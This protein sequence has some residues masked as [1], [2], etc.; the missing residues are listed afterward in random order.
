MVILFF[1][2]LPACAYSQVSI[3]VAKD[4]E[5]V[6][7]TS[8]ESGVAVT[9]YAFNFS[10][11]FNFYEQ[12]QY[13]KAEKYFRRAYSKI[14][15]REAANYIYSCMLQ[16][17]YE[18]E[19]DVFRKKQPDLINEWP[20]DKKGFGN[21]Y[22]DFGPRISANAN[23]GNID[24]ANGGFLYKVS[25][26]VQYWQTAT[27]L[28]QDNNLGNY[29]QYGLHSS[30]SMQLNNGWNIQPS[31]N[32]Y[33]TSYNSIYTQTA[34][35]ESFSNFIDPKETI[36][37]QT[38]G[39]Q[40]TNYAFPGHSHYLNLSV[41]FSK[42]IQLF[43]F[44]LEPAFHYSVDKST[45]LYQYFSNG[46]TDSFVN[47]IYKGSAPFTASGVGSSDTTIRSYIGQLGISLLYNWPAF[48]QMISTRIAFYYL[49]GEH[50]QSA[51]ALHFYS[52]LKLKEN[53]WIHLDW[54]NKGSLPWMLNSGDL[55]FNFT[56][57]I[58]NRSS[59]TFQLWPSKRLSPLFT[60]QYE[61]DTRLQDNAELIY[62]SFYFTL[63]YKL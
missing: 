41:S 26:S 16:Q 4:E 31:A 21:V 6:E 29:K 22:I 35:L 33:Y 57:K 30:L 9:N 39:T 60:Y 7:D 43:T 20:N 49:M 10:T 53:F 50:S 24:Y 13:A 3:P 58:D 12:K 56:D 19:A 36:F 5:P 55:Y 18:A 15:N 46:T 17:G 62:N 51:P 44:E 61:E 63:K 47:S 11:A 2:V 38:S 1:A 8:D 14:K 25:S 59:I 28:Q 54:L 40:T 52:L 34:D 45:T 27:Y 32:Y 23:A 37:Y 42:R 48:K